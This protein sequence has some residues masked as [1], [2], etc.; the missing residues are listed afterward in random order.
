MILGIG[1]DTVAIDAF[2]A[3]LDDPASSLLPGTFTAQEQATA[4]SRPSG[5]PRVH[6][7]ARFAAKEAFIKAW[8]SSFFGQKP[9]LAHVDLREI[10]VVHDRYGR[11]ALRLSGEV[12]T[13]LQRR[14][15]GCVTHLSLSHDGPCATAFVVLE[16]GQR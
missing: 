9:A 1:T 14:A 3:Q 2:S 12:A 11:P 15:P 7:A 5:Q 4:E 16:G 10:E 13:A 6:L 8:S